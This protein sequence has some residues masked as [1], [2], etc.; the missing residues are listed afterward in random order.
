MTEIIQNTFSN[1]N[2]I[3]NKQYKEFWEIFKYLEIK[4]F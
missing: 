2:R 4:Q 3:R 1:H